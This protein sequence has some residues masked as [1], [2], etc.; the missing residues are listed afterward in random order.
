MNNAHPT[1]LFIV[2]NKR[3]ENDSIFSKIKTWK[4]VDI[5]TLFGGKFFETPFS[6]IIIIIK[7]DF[8]VVLEG[9]GVRGKGFRVSVRVSF[10]GKSQGQVGF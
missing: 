3:E 9:Q 4:F 5:Y 2:V 1:H 8:G 10:K 7:V 6:L